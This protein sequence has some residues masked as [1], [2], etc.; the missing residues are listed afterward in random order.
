VNTKAFDVFSFTDLS[1]VLSAYVDH[2]RR[3]SRYF[4]ITAW[5]KKIG[6]RNGGTLVN[7][8]KKRRLPSPGLLERLVASMDLDSLG[9]EYFKTL[10]AYEKA[11]QS[12]SDSETI[13]LR[14]LSAIRFRS[15]TAV[16]GEREQEISSLGSVV[17][18]ELVGLRSAR[19][20][21]KWIADRVRVPMAPAEVEAILGKFV[22]EG[23]LERDAEGAYRVPQAR[24]ETTTDVSSEWIRKFHRESLSTAM[25]ALEEVPMERRHFLS[26]VMPI[27]TS[28][29]AEA[30]ATLE[31][32]AHEFVGEFEA[33]TDRAEGIYQLNLNFVPLTNA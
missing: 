23:V 20:D 14:A 8:M 18:K 22:R 16:M 10:V 24:V 4:S 32:F 17:V 1:E 15:K 3:T 6:L 12:G 27:E 13:F 5:A 25:R 9:A 30:K 33:S 19:G 26:Y 2:K 28:R 21:A 7:F 11:R 31:R 29:V